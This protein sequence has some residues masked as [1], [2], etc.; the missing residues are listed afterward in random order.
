MGQSVEHK[1]YSAS[2]FQHF[3]QCLYDQLA[4]LKQKIATPSFGQGQ[5]LLG[6][7]L[8]LYLID[9]TFNASLSNQAILAVID[10]PN[11]NMN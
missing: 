7:E 5:M 2:D 3:Q 1:R 6:A 8:E 9:K 11:F 4:I 10:D